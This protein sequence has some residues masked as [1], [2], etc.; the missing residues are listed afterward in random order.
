MKKSLYISILMAVSA[1]FSSCEQEYTSGTDWGDW[2]I[3]N[4]YMQFSTSVPT[5]ADK[6]VSNL[7]GRDFGVIGYQYSKTTNWGSAKVITK[8]M[9]DFYK[10]KVNCADNG[11]CEYDIDIAEPGNQL[12]QWDSD[13][14]YAF[15]AYH[16]YDGAGI[17]LSS[18]ENV[19]TPTLTYTYGWL[20]DANSGTTIAAHSDNRIFD[21]MTA[22]DIDLDGSR[23]V[24]LNFKHRLFAIEVLANNYNENEYEYEYETDEK[25]NILN[26]KYGNPIIKT[27]ENGNKVFAKDKDGNKKITKN[28]TQAISDLVLRIKGLSR[29]S[30]TIPLQDSEVERGTT[31]TTGTVGGNDNTVAFNISNKKVEIP[32]FDVTITDE[33][34]GTIRGGGYASSISKY[35]SE[36]S[37]GYVML[38]PQ[39]GELN[40]SLNWTWEKND[41]EFNT[42]NVTNTLKSTMEFEAGK[43]YQIIINFVGSGVTIALIEAGSWDTKNVPYTF[44]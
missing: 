19:S 31:Y 23:N 15:F 33:E 18:E 16:P 10:Q 8:P 25:G 11:V 42:E 40:F 37:T 38:I 44:E 4:G 9:P 24:A 14:R 36:N 3:F 22:E 21:L 39:Y 34:D 35:G 28:N 5:R 29:T 13:S 26:D 27:D 1:L 41:A 30:M 2:E 7:R 17:S 6:V 32:A 12:K 20:A 43:L